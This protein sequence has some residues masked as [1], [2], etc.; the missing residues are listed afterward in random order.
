MTEYRHI[1]NLEGFLKK[2]IQRIYAPDPVEKMSVCMSEMAIEPT[3]DEQQSNLDKLKV[4][5][6]IVGWRISS[7]RTVK[8]IE[9]LLNE[10]QEMADAKQDEDYDLDTSKDKVSIFIRPRHGDISEESEDQ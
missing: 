4:Q 7:D 1:V 8:I 6:A 10:E 3:E 5:C 9:D 2:V